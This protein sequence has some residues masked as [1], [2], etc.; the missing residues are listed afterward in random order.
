M[1]RI[2]FTTLALCIALTMTQAQDLIIDYDYLSKRSVYYKVNRKGDTI[3]VSSPIV[4]QNSDVL[5]RVRNFNEMALAAET[6]VSAETLV[7]ST[8]PFGMFSM[9]SPVFNIASKNVLKDMFDKNGVDISEIDYELGFSTDDAENDEQLSDVRNDFVDLNN[10][11]YD[12]SRLET[13]IENLEFGLNQL[14]QLSRNTM[15]PGQEIKEQ[16][17]VIVSRS[18]KNGDN[19]SL[20]NFYRA[21]ENIMED[22]SAHIHTAER[23]SRGVLKYAAV[24]TETNF[25]FSSA[26]NAKIYQEMAAQT[27]EL[28]EAIESFESSYTKEEIEQMLQM[29]QEMYFAIQNSS[30]TYNTTAVAEGDRTNI[31]LSF[32]EIPELETVDHNDQTEGTDEEDE[33]GDYDEDDWD[34]DVY[35]E[36]ERQFYRN[37]ARVMR[38]KSFKVKVSGGLKITPSFG[39]SFPSYGNSAKEF[40]SQGDTLIMEDKGDN[41]TPNISAFVNFYPYTG[42]AV[43]FG[44]TFGVGI[45]IKGSIAPSFMLGGALILGN[46]YRVTITG[47]MSTGPVTRLE[48]GYTVGQEISPFDDFETRTKYAVGFYTGISF[49]LT[50]K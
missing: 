6:E 2:I 5:V 45:P 44:G 31:N 20:T 29:M 30:F 43:N 33:D 10:S 42:R 17:R 4:K 1:K 3:Q 14:Y 36:A 18:L 12:L 7:E 38:T 40:Y 23:A 35:D 26:K 47:G 9:L 25:G 41:F 28:L 46:Q 19:P 21:R 37:Q 32:F 11:M 16:A 15:L 50:N 22:R 48:R 13:Q 34:Y 27:T 8:N 39:I 49:A 24:E